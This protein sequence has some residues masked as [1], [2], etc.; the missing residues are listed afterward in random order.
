MESVLVIDPSEHSRLIMEVSLR[1]AGIEVHSCADAEAG[2]IVL[3]SNRIDIIV[4][5][6]DL[7]HESGFNFVD[8]LSRKTRLFNIPI[9]FVTR[10]AGVEDKIH[11]LE[12]GAEDYLTKPI[13]IRE[14]VT[15]VKGHLERRG[16]TLLSPHGQQKRYDG[17]LSENLVHDIIHGALESGGTG[18]LE[19]GS[20]GRKGCVY[21]SDG[22][23]TDAEAGGVSGFDAAIKLLMWEEGEFSINFDGVA[24]PDALMGRTKEAL[25]R[26]L[27]LKNS[28]EELAELDPIFKSIPVADLIDEAAA[29]R[30]GDPELAKLIRDFNKGALDWGSLP[31]LTD[32]MRAELKKIFLGDEIELAPRAHGPVSRE[33]GEEPEPIETIGE[34]VQKEPEPVMAPGGDSAEPVEFV[35]SRNEASE[36]DGHGEID[37]VAAEDVPGELAEPL[38]SEEKPPPEEEKHYPEEPGPP[39]REEEPPPADE[40]KEDGAPPVEEKKEEKEEK[41]FPREVISFGYDQP[42]D[43]E[44]EKGIGLGKIAVVLVILAALAAG[45]YFLFAY[46]GERKIGKVAKIEEFDDNPTPSEELPAGEKAAA[47]VKEDDAEALVAAPSLVP[48]EPEVKQEIIPEPVEIKPPP[49]PRK[50]KRVREKIRK[51]KKKKEKPVVPP[52]ET[53]EDDGGSSGYKGLIKKGKAA[54]KRHNLAKAEKTFKTATALEPGKA[55]GY[56]GLGKVYME[57]GGFNAAE[58]EFGRAAKY[59]PRMA[60][61]WLMLGTA[62]QMLGKNAPAKRS[63]E[64]FLKLRPKGKTASEIREMLKSM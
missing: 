17:K 47:P 48:P 25:V 18:R 59:A 53:N 7:P 37:E 38:S 39:P 21:F 28:R 51:E 64:R 2:E 10:R 34:T 50:P 20:R 6:V 1:G 36:E 57:Q 24:R 12:L 8:R 43:W 29:G 14:F 23:I 63:Y 30:V 46:S 58:A 35:E 9:I 49:K 19:L 42:D 27:R 52:A 45:G 60:E 4:T 44:E 13:Y 16:L 40:K 15:R 61:A 22:D 41:E 62:Q 56:L 26:A 32:A 31:R 5:E 33:T 54:L 3:A 11:G 55:G